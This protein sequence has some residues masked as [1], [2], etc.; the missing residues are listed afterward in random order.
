M[1]VYIVQLKE[2]AKVRLCVK[3]PYAQTLLSGWLLATSLLPSLG[4]REEN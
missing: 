1:S 4:Q 2:L 3:T